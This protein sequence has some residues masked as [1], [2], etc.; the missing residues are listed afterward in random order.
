MSRKV[1]SWSQTRLADYDQCPARFKHKHLLKTCPLCFEGKVM[2]GYDSPAICD[3]CGEEIVKGEP[4]VRGTAVGGSLERFVKGEGKTLAP[5]TYDFGG[6]T[7]TVRITHPK[8]VAIAKEL[9][10]AH[11]K[12]KVIVEKLF[13]LD[14]NWN[15]LPPRWSPNV[16]LIVKMDI[17]RHVTA[18]SGK[19]TDW[20]TGGVEKKGPHVG[21][22]KDSEK[23]AE[24]LQIYSTAGLCAFP[25]MESMTSALCFVDAGPKYDPVIEMPSGYITRVDL[26]KNKKALE[27]R[28]LPLFKDDTFAPKANG[29]CGWC[30]FAKGKGGPC[31]Y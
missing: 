1:T 27:K 11:A 22:P 21:R 7:K 25:Q 23:Y 12:G 2:G 16:W 18:K 28:A 10:A 4:L 26:E 5:A 8:V 15:L 30:D 14:K 9:R 31:P 13:N 17:F 6:E 3:T 24:Q 20:K 29:R 19:V